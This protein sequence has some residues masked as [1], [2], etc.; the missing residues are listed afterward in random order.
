M[1]YFC[2]SEAVAVYLQKHIV[3]RKRKIFFGTGTPQSVVDQI[4][5]KH[6]GEKFLVTQSESSNSSPLTDLMDERGLD[7]STAVFV[8]PVSEDLS[9]ENL[10]GYD[11]IV[12]FSPFDVKSLKENYPDFRQGDIKF[13]AYG[14]SIVNAMEN[15]GLEIDRKSVV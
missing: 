11:M 14:K 4:G 1:K 13:L 3:F 2:T 15:A 8:K 12:L 6:K 7:Y 10:S 9:Q 5:P